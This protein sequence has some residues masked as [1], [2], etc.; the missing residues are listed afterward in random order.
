MGSARVI[1][2][3]KEKIILAKNGTQSERRLSSLGC[4]TTPILKIVEV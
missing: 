2:E 1:Y 3:L 4:D